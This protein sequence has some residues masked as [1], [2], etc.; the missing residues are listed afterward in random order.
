M[1][2][3]SICFIPDLQKSNPDPFFAAI[4]KAQLKLIPEFQQTKFNEFSIL[5]YE[6]FNLHTAVEGTYEEFWPQFLTGCGKV[7]RFHFVSET[8]TGKVWKEYFNMCTIEVPEFGKICLSQVGSL[9]CRNAF[10]NLLSTIGLS[11][12]EFDWLICQAT[13][14]QTFISGSMGCQ[15]SRLTAILGGEKPDHFNPVD[16]SAFSGLSPEA[17]TFLLSEKR[18]MASIDMETDSTKTEKLVYFDP[19][20]SK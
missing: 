16:F 9:N 3:T 5:G 13:G 1:A 19:P 12:H 4:E 8:S 18:G 2:R 15:W 7:I 17:T 11:W 20:L 14:C 10:G 6:D